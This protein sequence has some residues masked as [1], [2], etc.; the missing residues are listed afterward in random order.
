MDSGPS[1]RVPAL[2]CLLA[3]ARGPQILVYQVIIKGSYQ[4]TGSGLPPGPEG[5][6]YA[7]VERVIP[8]A[9]ASQDWLA[10]EGLRILPGGIGTMGSGAGG[11]SDS[12]R[13]LSMED[14][15]LMPGRN[16]SAIVSAILTAP[17]ASRPVPTRRTDQDSRSDCHARGRCRP[18]RDGLPSDCGSEGYGFKPRRPPH[19]SH[20]RPA[21]S[22]AER[23]PAAPRLL[24]RLL[25]PWVL[26][27]GEHH[28]T[29]GLAKRAGCE[30][31]C[32]DDRRAIP[33]P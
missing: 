24:Q 28:P 27:A 12:S 2:V 25:R 15:P 10:H 17:V 14:R 20:E 29:T 9:V 6:G 11:H 4:D 30:E 32:T 23:H 16:V 3:Y 5:E 18:S 1:E 7:R 13:S 31:D 19:F 8:P 22:G 21:W 33:A 26:T